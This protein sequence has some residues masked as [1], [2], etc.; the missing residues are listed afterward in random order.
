M[1]GGQSRAVVVVRKACPG[2]VDCTY[3][4]ESEPPVVGDSYCKEL[5]STLRPSTY[6]AEV[7]GKVVGF[8]IAHMRTE[9]AFRR[10]K[11]GLICKTKVPRL[12]AQWKHVLKIINIRVLATH[13]NKGIATQMVRH[14]L[15]AHKKHKFVDYE[16]PYD[17][18]HVIAKCLPAQEYE[19]ICGV[20]S[21]AG[22]YS[23]GATAHRFCF[24]RK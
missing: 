5:M 15:A 7:Q 8:I 23:S 22:A 19:Q 13:Q 3:E 11:R 9:A 24:E 2:D 10:E 17:K 18:T 12:G 4:I 21:G 1:V 16:T 14:V 6:C 20:Q